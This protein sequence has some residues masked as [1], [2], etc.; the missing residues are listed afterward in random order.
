MSDTLSPTFPA[1]LEAL[2]AA[3]NGNDF[4]QATR[5]LSALQV[6]HGKDPHVLYFAGALQANAGQPAAAITLMRHALK[7]HGGAWPELHLNLGELYDRQDQYQRALAHFTQATREANPDQPLWGRA[8]HKMVQLLFKFGRSQEAWQNLQTLLEAWPENR[9]YAN[10]LRF[11]LPAMPGLNDLRRREL[12][13]NWDRVFMQPL[14]P[15]TPVYSQSADPQRRLRIGYVSGDFRLHA[16]AYDL[17]PLFKQ[18]NPEQVELFA[19]AQQTHSDDITTWFQEH[20]DH[21][22]EIQTLS[23]QAVAEQIQADQIDI[24]VDCSGPSSGNRLGIFARKPAPIQIS[25]FGFVF[26]TGMQAIDY[27]FSDAVATPPERAAAFSE[28]LIHLPSQIHWAPLID[29]IANLPLTPPPCLSRGYITFGCGNNSYKLNEYVVALWAS[30]LRGMPQARL[31]LKH[32]DFGLPDMQQAFRQA[33][34]SHHINPERLIFSGKTSILEHLQFYNDID[35]AL[36]PF[37]Y[38]GG[39]TTCETL[40]MGT[41]LIALDGDGVRTSPSLLTLAG[42]SDL[43][44]RTPEQYVSLALKLA[45]DPARIAALQ[46]T[47]RSGLQQSPVMNSV[48]FARSVEAA[49]RA[50][51]QDWCAR[52]QT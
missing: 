45:R 49:Y 48:L 20:S 15:A 52:T 21:W 30:I 33:F 28:T 16:A 43:L 31:H 37:P 7:A 39:M 47:L 36:D 17:Y 6:E 19:Y 9:Q 13:E 32:T 1:Q 12:Y 23:D 35:I 29:E 4:Q 44:A 40:F 38:T 22:R 50:V 24:L 2:A 46:G 18:A 27:Q 25:A 42:A 26:T 3:V 5:L 8:Q 11:Y 14:R 34:A 41:P 10:T 51:W